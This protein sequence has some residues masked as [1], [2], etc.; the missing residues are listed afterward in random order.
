MGGVPDMGWSFRHGG[1]PDMVGVPDMGGIPDMGWSSR[2][3]MEFQTWG[4]IPDTGRSS[5][6]GMTG[7]QTNG[8]VPGRG[9]LKKEI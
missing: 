1:V 4:G 2:H 3:G 7:Y 6:H 8:G 9:G 5:R